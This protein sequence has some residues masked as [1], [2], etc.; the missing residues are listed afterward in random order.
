M[1][2]IRTAALDLALEDI[3]NATRLDL[4]FGSEAVSYAEATAAKSCGNK[5]G[6]SLGAPEAGD[7]D[8][9][10]VVVPAI[11]DGAV[12][13]TQTAGFWALT[14]GASILYATGELLADQVVTSGNTFSLDSIN[15]TIR[16][17]V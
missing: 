15:V 6:L 17:A 12:T 4:N 13:D 14:D 9:R 10:K 11:T 8:G 7:V 5:T 3:N 2:S 1:P 16:A